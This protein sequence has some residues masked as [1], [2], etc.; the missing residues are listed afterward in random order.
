MSTSQIDGTA[1]VTQYFEDRITEAQTEVES[2]RAAL[3]AAAEAKV[4]LRQG[5]RDAF[6]E[7][8]TLPAP[9][10]GTMVILSLQP[11]WQLCSWAQ[12]RIAD[13]AFKDMSAAGDAAFKQRGVEEKAAHAWLEQH[14]YTVPDVFQGKR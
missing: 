9:P 4:D 11:E 12:S 14:G 10:A 2:A 1:V 7:H 3:A 13:I 8:G 6:A 5:E